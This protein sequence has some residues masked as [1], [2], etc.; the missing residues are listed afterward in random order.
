[1]DLGLRGRRALVT[2]GSAGIGLAVGAR[3][4]RAGASV[5]IAGRDPARLARAIEALRAE[6]APDV[7][8]LR[9]RP[10]HGR[11]ARAGGG[12]RSVERFG[13]LDVLVNNV[14]TARQASFDELTDDDWLRSF[15][16]N[17]L[18]HVRAIRA[19]LPHLRASSQARIV[20]VASPP[21]SGPAPACPTTR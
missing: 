12:R 14:G 1:M 21:A 19:A 3:L 4:A 8:G 15:E 2:G 11:R 6:G 10:R 18:A 5:A 7:L 16:I 20:N 13:G 17:V 9:G